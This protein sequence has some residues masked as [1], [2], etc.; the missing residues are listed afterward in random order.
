[1]P[2]L[3]IFLVQEVKPLESWDKIDAVQRMQNYI[4]EH[5]TESITLYMLAQAAGYSPWHASRIFKK[6]IGK[7]PLGE[8][9][10]DREFVFKQ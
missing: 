10:G 8:K 5:L 6:L 1:M 9:H 7:T 2:C 3:M 4:E